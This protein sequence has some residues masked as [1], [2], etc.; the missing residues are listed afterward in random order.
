M[1]IDPQR[2]QRVLNETWGVFSSRERFALTVGSVITIALTLWLARTFDIPQAPGRGGALL[3][4]PAWQI[5]LG[6][7]WIAAIAGTAVA[8][9][10][11]GSGSLDGATGSGSLGGSS[12]GSFSTARWKRSSASLASW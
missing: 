10:A 4:Q 12:S 1:V 6:V 11:L 2:A 7:T 3:Q 9:P 8:S 5:A